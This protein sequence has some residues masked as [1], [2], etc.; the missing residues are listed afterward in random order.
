[1]NDRS[2]MLATTTVY[3]FWLYELCDVF[4]VGVNDD[5]TS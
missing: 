4:I 3:N 5:G 1:M 2:F